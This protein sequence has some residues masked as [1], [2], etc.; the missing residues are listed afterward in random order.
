MLLLYDYRIVDNILLLLLIQGQ[1]HRLRTKCDVYVKVFCEDFLLLYFWQFQLIVADVKLALQKD[2]FIL[3]LSIRPSVGMSAHTNGN[4]LRQSF[5]WSSFLLLIF[6]KV[7]YLGCWC[8]INDTSLWL[9]NSWHHSAANLRS[10]SQT[11]ISVEIKVGHSDL[12]FVVQG[13]CLIFW[14]LFDV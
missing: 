10:R 8:L 2:G 4:M 12:Y 3:L 14:R 13:F 5:A 7:V 9:Q 11:E 6:L 1:G